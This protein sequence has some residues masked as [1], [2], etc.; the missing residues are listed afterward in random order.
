[1]L[2]AYSD[3]QGMFASNESSA[4]GAAQALKGRN[5]KV[6]LVGFDWSPTL[7]DDLKSGLIDSLVVQDPF[8]MGY[9]AVKT[10]VDKLNGKTPEKFNNLAPK[11]VT[12][13][14]LNNPDVQK[15]LNP[16]LEKYLK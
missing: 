8:R 12:R 4:V 13:E 16:D 14:N 15:Q 7:L 11:V 6:R 9:E 1:M 3:L 2:T 5:S 10:A